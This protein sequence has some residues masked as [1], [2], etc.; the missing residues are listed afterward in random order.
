MTTR[1][2]FALLCFALLCALACPYGMALDGAGAACD[3]GMSRRRGR[4]L[5][6]LMAR[7]T[8]VEWRAEFDRLTPVMS[9]S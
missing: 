8:W 7:S 3:V 5:Y 9:S 1:V 2:R 4:H 6:Y